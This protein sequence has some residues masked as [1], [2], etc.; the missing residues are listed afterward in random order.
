MSNNLTNSLP[1]T[2]PCRLGSWQLYVYLSTT[3]PNKQ[4]DQPIHLPADYKPLSFLIFGMF[5]LLTH[6]CFRKQDKQNTRLLQR[7]YENGKDVCATR[8]S[9]GC[10]L[11]C[12][13]IWLVLLKHGWR[14]FNAM[15]Y[16]LSKVDYKYM[17]KKPM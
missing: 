14:I 8:G 11:C 12:I 2:R 1:L 16:H 15:A 10:A 6:M 3:R 17:T 13:F 7:P 4:H 5:S 9:A